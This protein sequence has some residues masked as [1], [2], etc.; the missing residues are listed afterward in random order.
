MTALAK[1]GT[2]MLIASHEVGFAQSVADEIV[3]MHGGKVLESGPPS[4]LLKTPR[5]ERTRDFFSRIR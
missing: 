5:H 1:T 2:T 4:Q 3:F